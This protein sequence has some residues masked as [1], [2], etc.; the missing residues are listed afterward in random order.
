[1]LAFVSTF[2]VEWVLGTWHVSA[3]EYL[4]WCTNSS[5][6]NLAGCGRIAL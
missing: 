6:T 2:V 5:K 1:M 4:L 3:W